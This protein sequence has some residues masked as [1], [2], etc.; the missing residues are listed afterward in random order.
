MSQYTDHLEYRGSVFKKIS[1]LIYIVIEL[2][3]QA[4]GL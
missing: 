2:E 4:F 1:D 3:D